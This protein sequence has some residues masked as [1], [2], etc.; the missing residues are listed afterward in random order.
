MPKGSGV[1]PGILAATSVIAPLRD[2]RA[3]GA[4]SQGRSALGR[5]PVSA[6]SRAPTG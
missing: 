3:K 5:K 1:G 2:G 6:W 4:A